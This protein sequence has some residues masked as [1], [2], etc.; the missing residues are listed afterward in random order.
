MRKNWISCLL[1]WYSW[2][3]QNCHQDVFVHFLCPSICGRQDHFLLLSR[4]MKKK[5]IELNVIDLVEFVHKE[6]EFVIWAL[7]IKL[8]DVNCLC[9]CSISFT[10]WMR[11]KVWLSQWKLFATCFISAEVKFSLCHESAVP[12][13][14]VYKCSSKFSVWSFN[15]IVNV[16]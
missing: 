5:L 11:A 7:L 13:L 9:L 16:L 6:V 3:E 15:V 4:T 8:D 1:I 14:Y 10:I 12:L 2:S